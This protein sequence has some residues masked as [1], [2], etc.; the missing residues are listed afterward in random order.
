MKSKATHSFV[1]L[2]VLFWSV[3]LYFVTPE[4]IVLRLGEQTLPAVFVPGALGGTSILFPFPYYLVVATTAAGG[5]NPIL[6]GVCES[7]C[8]LER[9]TSSSMWPR[10]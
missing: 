8:R 2:M 4:A 5:A 3:T 9:A 7:S 10:R 6:V 1:L